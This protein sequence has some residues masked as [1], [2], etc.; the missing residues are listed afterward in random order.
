MVFQVQVPKIYAAIS[1]LTT[2]TCGA[3][4]MLAPLKGLEKFENC[5]T[6]YLICANCT[7]K[8]Q[9]LSHHIQLV[10]VKQ[11]FG[12]SATMVYRISQQILSTSGPTSF[13]FELEIIVSF[14]ISLI[15]QIKSHLIAVFIPYRSFFSFFETFWK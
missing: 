9:N 10:T 3:L 4:E 11:K 1:D 6:L 7:S 14:L 2:Q 15:V 13:L 8:S 12:K 5:V